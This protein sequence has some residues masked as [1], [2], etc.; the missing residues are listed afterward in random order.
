MTVGTFQIVDTLH[1]ADWKPRQ[2]KPGEAVRV[3]TGAALPCGGLRVVMQENVERN[4]DRIRIVRR[5]TA[6]NIRL[7]G[8]DVKAGQPLLQAG[9]KLN[10]GALAMLATAGRV[11]PLVS[12]RLRVLHF[13]TGDEIVPPD[14]NPKP[15]QIRDS[16]SI[17]IRGLLANFS[18]DL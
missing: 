4:G 6:T 13:T 11:N 17:L 5:E 10:A 14:Q 16:N 15:G 9:S 3:A 1:A 7:R 2:L 12:P 18:C 8:E